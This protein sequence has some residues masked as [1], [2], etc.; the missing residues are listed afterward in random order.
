MSK[1]GF[2]DRISNSKWNILFF[3]FQSVTRIQKNKSL[4]IE[5][6]TPSE[7]KSFYTSS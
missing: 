2:N 6:V 1:K 7:I 4:T 5:L 3:N